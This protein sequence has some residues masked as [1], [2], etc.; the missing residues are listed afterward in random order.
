M[1]DDELMHMERRRAFAAAARLES[2]LTQQLR[3]ERIARVRGIRPR[4]NLPP[5]PGTPHW[6][7]PQKSY[8]NAPVGELKIALC[9]GG[10][11]KVQEEANE[12]YE[13]LGREFDMVVACNDIGG[14]WAG[15]L[16]HWCTLHPEKL[17]A[18]EM[19]RHKLRLPREYEVHFHREYTARRGHKT[20]HDWGGSSGLLAVKVALEAGADRVICAGIPMT[21][22]PHYHSNPAK[23]W[24]FADHHKR[25]WTAHMDVLKQYVRSMSGWTRDELGAPTKQWLGITEETR[26]ESVQSSEAISMVG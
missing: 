8:I 11:A 9:L 19:K 7:A 5:Q 16:T 17:N 6:F 25:G 18:W 12:A 3:Q 13:L 24:R 23:N 14:D 26:D 4:P 10:A 15:K 20:T 21:K 2:K 22:S 1:R